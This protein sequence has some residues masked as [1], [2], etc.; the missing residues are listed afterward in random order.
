MTEVGEAPQPKEEMSRR[1][2]LTKTS[3]GILLATTFLSACSQPEK[4]STPSSNQETPPTAVAE[5]KKEYQEATSGLKKLYDQENIPHHEYINQQADDFM[6]Y[7]P[8]DETRKGKELTLF[9]TL[10]EQNAT[11]SDILLAL[12]ATA[13]REAR[14]VGLEL[15]YQ[16]RQNGEMEKFGFEPLSDKEV[17]WAENNKISPLML[18]VAQDCFKPSLELFQA[19]IDQFLEAVPEEERKRII[20]ENEL[21]NRIPNPGVIA[22][23]LMTETSGWVNIGSQPAVTQIND[24]KDYFPTAKN[25]LQAIASWFS[26]NIPYQDHVDTLPGSQWPE[27]R[28]RQGI[29]SGGAI[30]PQM[31]P[32]NAFTFIKWYAKARHELHDE[33]PRANPFDIY[34]GTILTYLFIASEYKARHPHI[35][36]Y[37]TKIKEYEG[38]IR[39]GYLTGNPEKMKSSIYKWNFDRQQAQKAI[40]AGEDYWNVFWAENDPRENLAQSIKN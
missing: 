16:K 22:K 2:F 39:P 7:P 23:L 21:A 3:A 25:D 38:I 31:M 36:K 19:N 13:H 27:E 8:Q 18:A 17:E 20:K 15:L 4:D 26:Q 32:N 14:R 11:P 29:G 40:K 1:E 5:E 28:R 34:T 33:Y 9:Q 37:G 12:Q 6:D 24:K 35:D 10:E 30:G